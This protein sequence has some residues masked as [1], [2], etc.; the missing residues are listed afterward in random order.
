MLGER[1]PSIFDGLTCS[2]LGNIRGEV[3]LILLDG[4][5][6]ALPPFLFA[7]AVGVVLYISLILTINSGG[8][9]KMRVVFV[10]RRSRPASVVR[11]NL[12]VVLRLFYRCPNV[13]FA[14]IQKMHVRK[15]VCSRV[16]FFSSYKVAILLTA[17]YD[18]DVC[19]CDMFYRT[20]ITL[21]CS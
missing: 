21:S 12:H 3:S 15:S 19:V 20:F 9:D 16:T 18:T 14:N 6:L 11:V 1:C 7:L 5:Q 17:S 13:N 2:M 8:T 4:S 10:D